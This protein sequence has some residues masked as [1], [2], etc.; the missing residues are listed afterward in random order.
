MHG[1]CVLK[2][3]EEVAYLSRYTSKEMS[4]SFFRLKNKRP[5]D[6][7]WRDGATFSTHFISFVAREITLF[8][9]GL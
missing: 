5:G 9:N 8:L 3:N 7:S 6:A 4:P 2:N 1:S